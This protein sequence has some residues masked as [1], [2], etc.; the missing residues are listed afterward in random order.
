[1]LYYSSA[2]YVSYTVQGETGALTHDRSQA[3]KPAGSSFCSVNQTHHGPVC[4]AVFGSSGSAGLS[5]I[6]GITRLV[7]HC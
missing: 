3:V 7:I 2:V 1:M 5:W 4:S 6:T